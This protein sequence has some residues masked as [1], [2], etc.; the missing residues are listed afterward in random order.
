MP[1][2]AIVAQ[3]LTKRYGAFT[4]VDHVSFEVPAHVCFGILGP[5]GAGKTTT[6]RMI[7]CR[8]PPDE[9]RLLVLGMDVATQPREIK[10][11]VGLVPQENNLNEDLTLFE[12]IDLYG[13]FFGLSPAEARK[14]ADELIEFMELGPKRNEPVKALSGGMKRRGVIARALVNR[15]QLLV[16]DEPTTGLDPQARVLL[17]DRL[18]ALKAQ[19]VTLLLTT[20][21]MDE[22][23]RL[24]DELIIM[25]EGTI[26]DRGTPA[27]LVQRHVGLWAAELEFSPET[28]R[29]ALEGAIPAA[30]RRWEITD[31]GMYLYADED[32]ALMEVVHRLRPATYHIRPTNLEDVFLVRIGR[33]I[34]E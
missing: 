15:P 29:S 21:Y 12:N 16:L 25:H 8:F 26:V 33:E 20:H 13:R 17:W 6:I 24:C 4:A 11:K 3:N 19:G 7:N 30:V 2:A 27:E 34:H 5:N 32:Q 22:A 14:R 23:Q 9:G 31:Y 18:R 10:A 28:D 1:P